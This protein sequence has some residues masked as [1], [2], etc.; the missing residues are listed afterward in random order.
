[1]TFQFQGG[2]IQDYLRYIKFQETTEEMFYKMTNVLLAY[3]LFLLILM[4]LLEVL[5]SH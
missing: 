4:I 1:M 5:V 3:S 2:Y